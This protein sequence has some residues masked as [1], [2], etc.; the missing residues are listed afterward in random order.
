MPGEVFLR[1]EDVT[2]RTIEDEDFDFLRK[3]LTDPE[4]RTLLRITRPM[5]AVTEGGCLE[6]QISSDR[7]VTL[8]ICA[9]EDPKGFI[10]LKDI[11]QRV[12]SGELGICVASEFHG[13]GFGTEATRLLTRY[14]F[15]E[16]RL[17]RLVAR[18]FANNDVSRR[19]LEKLGFQE[20]GVHR[21][22]MF[23]EGEHFDMRYFSMLSDEWAGGTTK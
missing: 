1:G 21:D 13:Q 10:T 19:V 6:G 23:T 14:A 11:D 8:L 20:E 22:E 18:T 16:L 7:A 3:T 5:H 2:L 17:H 4:V 15:E 9:D 12:G